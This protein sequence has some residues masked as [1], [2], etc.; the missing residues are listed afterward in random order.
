MRR[1]GTEVPSRLSSPRI[2]VACDRVSLP[3]SKLLTEGAGALLI[4][5]ESD[6]QAA[7]TARETLAGAGEGTAEHL[8]LINLQQAIDLWESQHRMMA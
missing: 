2:R 3:A 5:C 1:A 4:E 6:Y 7:L 8:Q